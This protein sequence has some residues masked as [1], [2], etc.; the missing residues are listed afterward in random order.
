METVRYPT[1]NELQRTLVD[2]ANLAKWLIRFCPPRL[3]DI[4]KRRTVADFAVRYKLDTFVES[5][6]Y[7]G[8][9]V[10]HLSRY[11]KFIYS[12]EYQERLYKRAV[13][14]FANRPNIRIL[15][16]SGSDLIPL[17]LKEIDRS[18]LFWLDG[19]FAA[20]TTQPGEEACPVK[21]ELREILQ[22]RLDHVILIDD[23]SDFQ[24]Q[25][26]YPTV[27]EVERT[28]RSLRPNM[29]TNVAKNI[30]RIVPDLS[31]LSINP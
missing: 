28:V 29:K 13:E 21:D 1:R 9:T 20:G 17:I 27:E 11:C 8:A 22:H 14:R 12:V 10:E 4:V 18:A 7:L 25:L 26:G 23:A 15:H 5:G 31:Q 30:I 24:G 6:T 19:H 2:T 3:P 16:G